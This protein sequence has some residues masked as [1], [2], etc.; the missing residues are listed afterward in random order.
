MNIT[1]NH[2]NIHK[3]P[4]TQLAVGQGDGYSL[5]DCTTLEQAIELTQVDT[6]CKLTDCELHEQEGYAICKND[7]YVT[8]ITVGNYNDHPVSQKIN[9][10]RELTSF[11]H[12]ITNVH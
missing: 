4:Y 6:G 9:Q 8:V 10:L 2:F 7:R 5:S 1:L 12:N 11:L 3:D